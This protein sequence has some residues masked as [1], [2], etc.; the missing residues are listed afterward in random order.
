MHVASLCS[1]ERGAWSGGWLLGFC[2]SGWFGLA[3]SSGG[4]ENGLSV[5]EPR[6]DERGE[7]RH[8]KLMVRGLGCED[9]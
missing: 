2:L 7:E 3:L 1:P 5:L 4:L 8:Q 6:G 9:R